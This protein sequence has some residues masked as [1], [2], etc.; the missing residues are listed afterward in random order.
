MDNYP[1]GQ[2]IFFV[3]CTC[4]PQNMIDFFQTRLNYTKW[5]HKPTANLALPPEHLLK[6]YN[7]L[8]LPQLLAD[9]VPNI[10][11]TTL[12]LT[13]MLTLKKIKTTTCIPIDS[14]ETCTKYSAWYRSG[15]KML[16]TLD[17]KT[18][19]PYTM[20]PFW[21]IGARPCWRESSPWRLS[22]EGGGMKR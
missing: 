16:M 2:G 22:T 10:T 11:F 17:I 5:K 9:S 20:T 12:M 7:L 15:G 14:Y 13:L 18:N 21:L 6:F 19:L 4:K 8:L 3:W 1:N